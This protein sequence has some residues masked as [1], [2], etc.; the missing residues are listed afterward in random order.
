MICGRKA[1]CL[2]LLALG[3][4]CASRPA[5]TFSTET[6]RRHV[7]TLARDIGSRP[8]GSEA[9]AR[10]RDYLVSALR[11]GGFP[12]VQVRSG[13][14]RRPDIGLTARVHNIV[15]LKPGTRPEAIALV[16]HYDSV[17]GSPGATDDALGTAV[18]V[19]AGRALAARGSAQY[20]LMVLLTDGEEDGLL[21]AAAAAVDR[22]VAYRIA[23]FVNLDSIGSNG[24]SLM[25]ESGPGNGWLVKAWARAAPRPRG[26]SFAGDIYR[27]LP[28]DTDFSILKRTGAPGLNFA[29]VGDSYAYHTLRDTAAR[30]SDAT[31]RQTGENLV[32]IVE[33][34][35]GMD[36]A[37]RTMDQPVYFD[38]LRRA[39]I[40]YGPIAS[41]LVTILA[42]VC[43]L[44]G[45][46][47]AALDSVRLAGPG[48]LAFAA[49]WANL[50]FAACF[51]AMTLATVALR[52]SREAYHPWYARPGRLFLLLAATGGG[53]A[54]AAAR[55]GVF[56]PEPWHGVRHPA[57]V[58]TIT[59]PIWIV[60]AAL[61]AVAAPM[62][63][64]LW[65]IP[66]AVAGILLLV[67]PPRS[68]RAMRVASAIVFA[69]VA[70]LWVDNLVALGSFTV[71]VLGRLPIITPA[72]I[73]PAFVIVGALVL[74]PPAVA[75]VVG[76]RRLVRPAAASAIALLSIAAAFGWAWMAPAYTDDRPLRRS[77]R[78]VEDTTTGTAF[79]EIGG[80]EPGLDLGEG[81]P[82]GWAPVPSGPTGGV[83]GPARDEPAISVP[84]G[85]FSF[86]FAFR[87]RAADDELRGPPPATATLAHDPVT[88]AVTVRVQPAEPGLFAAI[89]LPEPPV[90]AS[91]PGTFRRG[92]W[93]AR[94]AGVPLDG[95]AF[96]ARL[97]PNTRLDAIRVTIVRDALP[98]GTAARAGAPAW[99]STARTAWDVSSAWILAPGAEPARVAPP[100]GL[101]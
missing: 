101:R 58:W 91:L 8:L 74:A 57:L 62:S 1:T 50:G 75:A 96:D 2:V 76:Q 92:R 44:L 13:D 18:A 15:A 64:Y 54:W 34:L 45:W 56:L 16:A 79:W 65:T 3:A 40:T 25:F 35:D 82:A 43:G 97:P 27:R 6:A 14:A 42:L 87:R 84:L 46:F 47:R 30:L 4:G 37:R 24:P 38:V 69:V 17:S 29:P 80:V 7:N 78:Y 21:G 89:V 41:L 48:R 83:E 61:A 67:L 22:D 59:L 77:A 95:I 85:G 68:I 55:A 36:L 49:L 19:E 100:P 66:L 98:S 73:F 26:G 39:A 88:R 72:W 60:I 81:A 20:G 33:A 53:C 51:A 90:S 28:N 86:P 32:A 12:D 63:A 94:Y 31:I 10:A 5:S 9:N 93:T 11:S 52:A 99:L 23:T 71:A 70:V